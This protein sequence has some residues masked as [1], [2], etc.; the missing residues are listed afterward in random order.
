M[1]DEYPEHYSLYNTTDEHYGGEHA[2]D[3]ACIQ[4]PGSGTYHSS[5]IEAYT[6]SE[7]TG[8]CWYKHPLLGTPIPGNIYTA[9]LYCNGEKR[10]SDVEACEPAAPTFD[11]EKNQGFTC[12][13]D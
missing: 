9:Y 13:G 1:V 10:A 7:K 5:S 3:Y 8:R 12:P 4:N 6:V 2:V 11:I